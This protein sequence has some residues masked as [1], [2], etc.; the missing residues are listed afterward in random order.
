MHDKFAD[1]TLLFSTFASLF[2]LHTMLVAQQHAVLGR[3]SAG[4]AP[5]RCAVPAARLVI[6][7]FRWVSCNPR[8]LSDSIYTNNAERWTHSLSPS[9]SSADSATNLHHTRS[10]ADMCSACL[11]WQQQ[12]A[13][14]CPAGRVTSKQKQGHASAVAASHAFAGRT[15]K[16]AVLWSSSRRARQTPHCRLSSLSRWVMPSW[17]IAP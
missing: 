5:S 13:H 2:C 12:S 6:R 3:R 10:H 15:S 7:R 1:S 16:A 9:C 4:F 8:Q 14:P 11:F 17:S